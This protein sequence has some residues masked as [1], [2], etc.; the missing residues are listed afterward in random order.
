MH[1]LLVVAQ[2]SCLCIWLAVMSAS[3]DSGAYAQENP[4]LTSSENDLRLDLAI[5]VHDY[6]T[7]QVREHVSIGLAESQ[8]L[9][10]YADHS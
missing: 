3:A 2:Y 5:D 6:A 9:I 1:F 7:H 8:S 10:A 4:E